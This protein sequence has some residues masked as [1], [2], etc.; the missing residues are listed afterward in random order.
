MNRKINIT[1]DLRDYIEKLYYEAIRYE[2]FLHTVNRN[3]CPMTDEEWESSL[4]YYR[5]LCAEARISFKIAMEEVYELYK[6]YIGENEWYIDF[7]ECSIIVGEKTNKF[8]HDRSKESYHDQLHRLYPKT[9]GKPLQINDSSCKDIT[10]QVT[11]SCNMACTYC[12][13]HNKGAHSMSFEMGKSFIDML[14]DADDKTNSYIDSKHTI[15]AIINFIGGEPWLEIDLISKLSDYFIGELFRRKHPWA[16]KFMFSV[17][18]NGLLHFDPKV[19]EY[20]KRHKKHLGY[21]ISIDGNKELHD[22]CR[23]DLYGNGT[24]ERAISAVDNY[25]NEMG[26]SIGSKMTIA[27]G[28][29]KNVKDAVISMIDRGYRYINLNCVYEEGWTDEHAN[30]LYWQL[31]YLTDW[32]FENNLQDEVTLSI[33]SKECGHS[34]S[35][36]DNHNW[37]GGTGLMLAVDWKGDIYPC[38]R[39]MESSVGGN[40]PPYIIGNIYDGIRRVKEHCDR[41]SCLE[42]ITRRS[43]STDECYNCPIA[44]GCGWCSAYNYELFGTP[45]KRATFICC[46]HKARVLANVYYW[47]KMGEEYSL[48][49]PKEW[50]IPIIGEEEYNN[51]I[52]ISGGDNHGIS[53]S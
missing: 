13:Q 34:I 41:V 14:L 40:Q 26:G 35:E 3:C 48:D 20:I 43:Q 6:E 33:F 18:S 52:N 30:E 11:D 2:D 42:C 46:M 29:V 28:N 7:S 39:Y 36:I 16:I 53:N 5:I 25:T 31:H 22:S 17:C 44:Q 27:P 19:Q 15:G 49:C 1:D 12:Y 47:N 21:N 9:D 50:A 37:C 51:L 4:S 32:L 23:I 8:S 10:I 45:D 38:L 24:Y